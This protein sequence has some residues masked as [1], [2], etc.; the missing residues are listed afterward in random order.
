MDRRPVSFVFVFVLRSLLQDEPKLPPDEEKLDAR[1]IGGPVLGVGG[2]QEEQGRTLQVCL[3]SSPNTHSTYV[4]HLSLCQCNYE[5]VRLVHLTVIAVLVPQIQEQIIDVIKVIPEEW[6]SKQIVQQIVDVPAQRSWWKSWSL[7][8]T[9]VRRQHRWTCVEPVA[10]RRQ[11][12][13]RVDVHFLVPQIQEKIVE[14]I[15]VILQEQCQRMRLFTFGRRVVQQLLTGVF[16]GG[17]VVRLQRHERQHGW[18]CPQPPG[19]E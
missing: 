5:Q 19:A 13:A 12:T 16:L 1:A 18:T 17:V 2:A 3:S 14:V 10:Y 4:F 15:K 7:S 8:L 9:G 6:M 11:A